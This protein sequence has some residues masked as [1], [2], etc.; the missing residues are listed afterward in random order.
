MLSLILVLIFVVFDFKAINFV[1]LIDN[2]LR[3]KSK[4]SVGMKLGSLY[5]N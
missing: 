2:N 3:S 4:F 5:L 1:N